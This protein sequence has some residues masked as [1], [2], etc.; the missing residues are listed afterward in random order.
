M[1][2][3]IADLNNYVKQVD[4]NI[5]KTYDSIMILADVIGLNK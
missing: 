1:T 4:D 5:A 2:K 3:K